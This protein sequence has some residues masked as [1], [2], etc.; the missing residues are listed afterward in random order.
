M[1]IQFSNLLNLL[2]FCDKKSTQCTAS[3]FV[4]K[5]MDKGIAK[6]MINEN[7][8]TES[9]ELY[10]DVCYFQEGAQKK[11]LYDINVQRS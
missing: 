2:F 5:V 11:R 7:G 3:F 10:L 4:A 8:H 1:R 6:N 9:G